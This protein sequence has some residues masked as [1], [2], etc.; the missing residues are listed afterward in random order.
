MNL[1]ESI[2]DL[3]MLEKKLELAK[4]TLT[5]LALPIL[6]PNIKEKRNT[7]VGC[8][9]KEL[10]PAYK[11]GLGKTRDYDSEKYKAW[12]TGVKQKY[13]FVCVI[14]GESKNLSCHHL[15]SWSTSIEGRY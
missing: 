13:N 5:K 7:K 6:E 8:Q 4:P 12:I 1:G 9:V 14:T 11:H 3:I 2:K 10:H 15:N